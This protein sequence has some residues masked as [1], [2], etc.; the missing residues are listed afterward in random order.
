MKKIFSAFLIAMLSLP[1]FPVAIAGPASVSLIG[2]VLDTSGNPVTSAKVI[3]KTVSGN[4][5]GEASVNPQG[6][7]RVSEIAPGRYHL[8]L[9]SQRAAFPEETVVANVSADGLTVNWMVSAA[10][11]VAMAQSGTEPAGPDWTDVM[12]GAGGVVLG[13]ALGTGIAAAAGGFDS[14]TGRRAASPSL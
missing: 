10:A 6:R 5:V 4:P 11:A 13:G 9:A 14:K 12:I 2:M 1:P 7:Y 8:T 3:V